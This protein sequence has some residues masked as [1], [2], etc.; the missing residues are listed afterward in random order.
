LIINLQRWL[1]SERICDI[2]TTLV[3]HGSIGE[4]VYDSELF[5]YE[6]ETN[7]LMQMH[8]GKKKGWQSLSQE[9]LKFASNGNIFLRTDGQM[10]ERTRP[11]THGRWSKGAGSGSK[12]GKRFLLAKLGRWHA[13]G[14]QHRNLS[15]GGGEKGIEAWKRGSFIDGD[16]VSFLR[17]G[18]KKKDQCES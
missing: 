7:K 13:T 9:T 4:N 15:E 12:E 14:L 5:F 18:D 8:Q 10:H 11:R 6:R 17:D 16:A 3:Y 2:Y 1:T